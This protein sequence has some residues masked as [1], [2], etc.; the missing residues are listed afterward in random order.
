MCLCLGL[1]LRRELFGKLDEVGVE[2]RVGRREQ[3]GQV[4]GL[5]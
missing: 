5:G 3:E 4:L 2:P 1:E